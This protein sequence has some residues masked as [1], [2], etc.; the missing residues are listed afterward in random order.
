[1]VGLSF[2]VD[3]LSVA[4]ECSDSKVCSVSFH[5]IEYEESNVLGAA[6]EKEINRLKIA[7]RSINNFLMKEWINKSTTMTL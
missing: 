5:S 1:M 6:N 2:C 3:W 4:A 7:E